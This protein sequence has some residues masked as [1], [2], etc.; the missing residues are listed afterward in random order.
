[1]AT[2]ITSRGFSRF[3]IPCL[4]NFLHAGGHSGLTRSELGFADMIPT[5]LERLLAHVRETAG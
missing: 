1:L 3:S 2:L 5:G 4:I